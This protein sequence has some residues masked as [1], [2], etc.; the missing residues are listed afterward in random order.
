MAAA[1]D[2]DVTSNGRRPLRIARVLNRPGRDRPNACA[3]FGDVG[4]KTLVSRARFGS[5][6]AVAWPPVPDT[7]LWNAS[8]TKSATSFPACAER[9]ELPRLS[10]REQ[11][12]CAGFPRCFLCTSPMTGPPVDP[13]GSGPSSRRL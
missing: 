2:G 10:S 6:T 5:L 13:S 11:L 3:R 7:L 8:P 4:R 9:W 1:A 12:A